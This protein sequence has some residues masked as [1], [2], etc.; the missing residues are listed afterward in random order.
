MPHYT[1][2]NQL[3]EINRLATENELVVEHLSF[4]ASG[5][6]TTKLSDVYRHEAKALLTWL[7]EKYDSKAPAP[8]DAGEYKKV[9]DDQFINH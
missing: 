7:N 1:T 2:I 4:N 9:S 3:S 8:P 5:G 6:R